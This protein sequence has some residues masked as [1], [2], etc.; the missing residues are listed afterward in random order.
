MKY[1]VT[2]TLKPGLYAKVPQDQHDFC[3]TF[4]LRLCKQYGMSLI[5][6]LTNDNNCH[7]HGIVDL[8]DLT[9]RGEFIDAFRKVSKIFG[10]KTVNQVLYENSY[11]QYMLKDVPKTKLFV[12]DPIVFDGMLVFTDAFVQPT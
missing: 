3:H 5:C 9:H 12:L 2:L 8:R 7:Y 1:E 6:E 11:I 10:R 4:L